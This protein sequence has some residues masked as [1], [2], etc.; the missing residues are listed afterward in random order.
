M[1]MKSRKKYTSRFKLEAVQLVTEEG[2]SCAEVV[3]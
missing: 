1:T 2:Y 3:V